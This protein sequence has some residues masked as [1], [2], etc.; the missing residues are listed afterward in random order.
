LY[1]Y[2]KAC[3]L[4]AWLLALTA[5]IG[6]LISSEI[7]ALPVC[8]LCWYQRIGIFPLALI[9]GI[10]CYREENHVIPYVIA[11]PVISG[12]LAL[13]QYLQQMIP[14]F[15]PIDLCG[16]GPSCADI[17][18]M[19]LGFITLPLLSF[20]TSVMIALLLWWAGHRACASS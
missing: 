17:H 6:S 11:L 1:F 3:L 12:L 5:S 15:A 9:L 20:I 10:A 18:W 13:Y 4:T 14:G 16:L 19:A 8:H 7:I 2:Q